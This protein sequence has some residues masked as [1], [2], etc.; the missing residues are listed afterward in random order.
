MGIKPAIASRPSNGDVLKVP[1]IQIVALLCILPKI[2][3]WYERGNA[4]TLSSKSKIKKIEMKNK[5]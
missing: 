5:K 1:R 2:F 4:Y 3:I